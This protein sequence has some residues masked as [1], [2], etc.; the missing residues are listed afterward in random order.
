[1]SIRERLSKRC[2]E[3]LRRLRGLRKAQVEDVFQ[4]KRLYIGPEDLEITN[5]IRRRP[6]SAFN[7]GAL[8]R[9]KEL[10]ILPRCI[11]E[12]YSY[13]SSIAL[14]CVDVEEML[15]EGIHRPLETRLILWPRE[16][17]DI[18]GCEDAR[19]HEAD[20]ENLLL[21]TGVGFSRE[22]GRLVKTYVQGLA[23]FDE[24]WRELRRGY[25]TIAEEGET[26]R[27]ETK[28][29]A[30]LKLEGQEASMLTRPT[31][32][33]V[34]LCW[35]CRADLEELRM[36]SLD[37]VMAPEEWES[38]IGWST[39]AL[40]LSRDE[41]LIGWHGASNLDLAFRNGLAIVDGDGC[42]LA[43]SDYLLEPRG[44][45][46]EY[47]DRPQTLFG[48]GLIGY[49]EYLLCIGGIGDCCIGVFLADM[50]EALE[51]LRWLEG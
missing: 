51:R 6:V 15:E 9:D 12:F 27:P 50:E 26:Y 1:M 16:L 2:M 48:C 5:Y 44:L 13:S 21:Y 40:R 33:D 46:E 32:E 10:L 25:F 4:V 19:I 20:D 3:A 43:V 35:R 34:R 30:I 24:G 31:I 7:P 45:V 17:W 38:R 29:S 28:D 8:L 36:W 42:L 23:R 41:Y 47:G 14:F 49:D 11:F 39:N 22:S 18:R 37:P